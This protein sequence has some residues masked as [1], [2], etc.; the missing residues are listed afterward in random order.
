[1]D[2]ESYETLTL[3]ES[4]LGDNIE[5]LE[6]GMVITIVFYE[7]TPVGAELPN[8]VELEVAETDPGLKGDTA[9]GGSKPAKLT[10]GAVIQV[11]LFVN[12]GD[13]IRVDTRK[14]EYVTR[15]S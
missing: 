11:P 15:V 6:E 1:M 7:G 3:D 4:L 5:F 2:Q 9:S 12:I 14:R 10:S 13:K 8:F